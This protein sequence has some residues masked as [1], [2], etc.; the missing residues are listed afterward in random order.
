MATNESPKPSTAVIE[1]RHSALPFDPNSPEREEQVIRAIPQIEL[2]GAEF[3]QNNR[4][5]IAEKH[6]VLG[7]DEEDE[8]AHHH[9]FEDDDVSHVSSACD[10]GMDDARHG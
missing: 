4:E 6:D 7:I 5:D 8:Q 2:L 10:D 9:D 3:R 1:K